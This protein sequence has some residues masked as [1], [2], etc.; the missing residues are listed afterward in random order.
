MTGFK[1][2]SIYIKNRGIVNSSLCFNDGV[3]TSFDMPNEYLDLPKNVTILPG[4]IDKHTHGANK[5]D[6]MYNTFTDLENICLA[7]S[8][9]G[10]TS[11][12]ATTITASI[13]ETKSAIKTVVDFIN[14]HKLGKMIKGIHLEGPFLGSKNK[15]AQPEQFL[16]KGTIENFN[17]MVGEN[18]KYIKQITIAPECCDADLIKFLADNDICV[19]VG[20]SSATYEQL[21][22]ALNAG[23]N[24]ITHMYN[25]MSPLHHREI[26]VVGTGLLEDKFYCELIGDLIHV[27]KNAIKVLYKNKGNEKICLITDSMEASHLGN[28]QFMLGGQDVFVKDKQARLADGVLAGSVLTMDECVKNI[29]KV[30]ELDLTVVSDMASYNSAKCLNMNNIGQ[31]NINNNADFTIVDE[32]LDVLYTIVSGEVIYRK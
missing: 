16:L 10:V 8:R 1:D 4:Y 31:I 5:S 14:T 26:G 32:N 23:A 17:K 19:S 28:G 3:I 27:S 7:K 2:C 24:C 21:L 9:E 25:A 22:V 29:S 30:L 20:H 13:D 11:L 12:L 15:G 18:I 6:F